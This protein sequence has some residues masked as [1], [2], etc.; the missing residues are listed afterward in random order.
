MRMP[1][2]THQKTIKSEETDHFRQRKKRYKIEA[3]NSE[4]K[5]SYGLG[6]YKY[7]GLFGMKM[8]SYMTAFVVNAKRIARVLEVI[9][10]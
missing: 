9:P 3:K 6:K 5:Q 4:M 10:V 8:Q 1:S 7:L 2:E